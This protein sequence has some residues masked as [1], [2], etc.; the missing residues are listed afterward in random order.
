[1]MNENRFPT[2]TINLPSQG[3]FY[4]KDSPFRSGTVELK[5]MTAKEEDIL[6]STNLIRSGMVFDKL[7]ESLMVGASPNNLLM[8]DI[9]AALLATRVLA[10]GKDYVV[11]ITCENC[12]VVTESNIDLSQFEE[13]PLKTFPNE[14]GEF[15]L[16]LPS[17]LTVTLKLLTRGEELKVDRE[18]ESI[19]KKLGDAVNRE[20]S[21]RLRYIITSIN[22]NKDPLFITT[23]VENLIV[24]DTRE[25]RKFYREV[26]PELDMTVTSVCASCGHEQKGVLPVGVDFFWPDAEI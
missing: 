18:V 26:S 19:N 15:E 8:G 16:T 7:L 24:R 11:N 23:T 12:N 5:Y 21:T 13:K 14:N 2:E 20:W 3:K 17:G 10:Y 1:M 25:I 4:P 22:G 6:T 9:N